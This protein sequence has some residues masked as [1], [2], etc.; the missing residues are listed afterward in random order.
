MKLKLLR[1]KPLLAIFSHLK[2]RINQKMTKGPSLE[3]ARKFLTYLLTFR[4]Q[5][6]H[7]CGF[8][9]CFFLAAFLQLPVSL[10]RRTKFNKIWIKFLIKQ[11]KFLP[12]RCA[13]LLLR[14]KPLQQNCL[15]VFKI[16]KK[17]VRVLRVNETKV[18]LR[19]T[20]IGNIFTL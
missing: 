4:R 11:V 6:P 20:F 17:I 19:N 14:S 10:T 16:F 8:L 7:K 2:V 9:E 13:S 18:T 1:E 5:M 12:P 15:S 3:T